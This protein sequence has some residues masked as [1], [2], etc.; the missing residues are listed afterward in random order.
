MALRYDVV[1]IISF[2]G[3]I[4]VLMSPTMQGFELEGSRESYA[5]FPRWDPCQ[6]GSLSVEFRS[7][8]ENGVLL[9]QDDGGYMDFF[10][11][12]LIKG[13]LRLRWNL[14]DRAMMLT[15]ISDNLVD[16]QW[17]KM[18]IKRNG[19]VTSLIIDKTMEVSKRAHS[20][21]DLNFGNTSSNSAVYIGGVPLDYMTRL[22]EL[23]LPSIVFESKFS[24]YVRNIY[25]SDCGRP[26]KKM[27]MIDSRGVRTSESNHCYNH[28]CI[29]GGRCI[30]TNNGSKC[31]CRATGYEGEF[32]EIGKPFAKLTIHKGMHFFLFF[33]IAI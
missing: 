23:A 25:Y 16:D 32:C 5:K 9:Y 21:Q 6:N 12:K 18:E 28:K 7:T 22:R 27:S 30:N 1:E 3:I 24:G 11:V 10:E 15:S 26:T 2:V 13:H 14:G 17:H 8:K 29:N 31:D 33:N 4:L 20:G 19:S